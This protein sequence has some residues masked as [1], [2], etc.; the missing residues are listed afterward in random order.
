MNGKALMTLSLLGIALAVGAAEAPPSTATCSGCH[1]ATG[2]GNKAVGAPRLAG[3]DGSYLLHQLAAFK[4]GKRATQP[5]DEAAQTMRAVAGTLS[6]A[7]MQALSSF[8]GGLPAPTPAEAV[9]QAPGQ[10]AGKLIFRDT[11]APCHGLHAQGYPQMH[12]PSLRILGGWYI[13]R[14]LDGYAKGLRGNAD[15]AELPAIWM[16]SIA[17]HISKPRDRA[18]LIDY[19]NS[20]APAS[21][22]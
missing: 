14:Q 21:K 19:L 1:G 4:S 3:Q 7:D 9:E 10:T 17:T 15:H 12:A 11:C 20:L 6:D 22:Q 2:E 16:R 18:D 5:G 8:Y 13:E